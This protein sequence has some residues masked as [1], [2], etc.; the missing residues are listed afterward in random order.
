[1]LADASRKKTDPN[2]H[3]FPAQKGPFSESF[4][5]YWGVFFRIRFFPFHPS[6]EAPFL[7][8]SVASVR[9]A[10]TTNSGF[11]IA[12]E[13]LSSRVGFVVVMTWGDQIPGVRAMSETIG[14]PAS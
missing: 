10:T 6:L 4:L 11:R 12:D 14:L 7:P 8:A 3:A 1:M 2:F 5:H 9:V 13:L